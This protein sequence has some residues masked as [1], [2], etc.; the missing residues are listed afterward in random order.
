MQS[1]SRQ[2]FAA[3]LV[4]NLFSEEE[5]RAS[6]VAGKVGKIKLD[7][8]RMASVQLAVM[9]LYPCEVGERPEIA[10]ASCITAIDEANRRLKRKRN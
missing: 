5:R 10:W 2:N 1:C 7:M 9:Q 8:S 6:N 3:N 4:R